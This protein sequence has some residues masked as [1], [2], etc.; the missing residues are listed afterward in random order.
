MRRV[1]ITQS[2]LFPWVGLLEQIKLA[3]VVVHYDDVQFSKGSFV[4]R[5]QLKFPL[6]IKW[7]TV[8]LRGLTLGQRI[9][10]VAIDNSRD[11][12]RTHHALLHGSLGEAP[13]FNEAME[14]VERC[15]S[16]SHATIATLARQS[17]LECAAYFG[18]LR[19]KQLLDVKDLAISGSSTQR[20]LDVVAAVGGTEYI[21][22]HGARAYLDHHA[23]EAN[24][25]SVQYMDYQK[26]P[27]R[28][29]NGDFTPFVSS[30]DLIANC[31]RQ[32]QDSIRSET[33]SW[34]DFI[35]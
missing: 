24:G 34:R 16:G 19:D 14:I 31:G 30:L 17:L 29:Q 25:V 5:V 3:D 13:Y 35:A 28:Q 8:P 26:S 12:R 7:M 15:Y 33:V 32:G 2:M 21:T 20:V 11:W 23:F 27:Y 6:G 9:D 10:E 22:G 1:V 18:L 4:N